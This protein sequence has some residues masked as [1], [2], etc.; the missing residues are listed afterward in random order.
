MREYLT[1]SA[2]DQPETPGLWVFSTCL[3]FIRTV[4]V[5]QRDIHKPDDIDSDAE[6]HSADAARYLIQSLG[7]KQAGTKPIRGLY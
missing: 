3:N 4:P 7:T 2:K 1:E 6:D 5:L